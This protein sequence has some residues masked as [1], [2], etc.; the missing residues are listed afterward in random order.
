M[1]IDLLKS[2]LPQTYNHKKKKNGIS[3][4]SNKEKLNKMRY[5]YINNGIEI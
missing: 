4:K 5:A 1:L 3:A 2:G